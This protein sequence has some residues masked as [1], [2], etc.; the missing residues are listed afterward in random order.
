MRKTPPRREPKK[1]DRTTVAQ[2]TVRHSLYGE[3]PLARH[4]SHVGDKTYVYWQPDPTYKP[5]LPRGAVEGDVS[6]Q[7][8]CGCHMPKY[9][10]L[11][12]NRTC[13]QCGEP[14]E[15]GAHEQKYWY[16]VRKFNFHSVPVRCPKCRR[17]RRSERAVREQI[18]V[19]RQALRDAPQS[20]AAQVAL[21]RALVEYHERASAGSLT[22]AIA[23]A[24]KAAKLRPDIPEPLLWEGIAHIR[25]GRP[26]Q[27]ATCLSRYLAR[28]G[29][30]DRLLDAKARAYLDPATR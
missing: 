29:R 30:G 18:A 20:S 17:L 4:E 8:F 2:R 13:L 19:A 7:V 24:R 14:F 27:G 3:I 10:Y 1:Y 6:R 11:S 23:A 28:A 5:S 25:A 26:R 21:A 12:E 22:D 16:E 9:F 15:F